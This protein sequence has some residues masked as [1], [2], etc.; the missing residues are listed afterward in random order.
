[1]AVAD[2]CSVVELKQPRKRRRLV[3]EEGEGSYGGSGGG[4]GAG[5]TE[6]GVPGAR[7]TGGGGTCV[8]LR[9]GSTAAAAGSART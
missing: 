3:A 1:V 9:G 6:G 8:D 5:S 7:A 4:S 2:V